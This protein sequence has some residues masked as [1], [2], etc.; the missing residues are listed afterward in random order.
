MT[1]GGEPAPS[2]SASG[3]IRVIIR[4]YEE[5]DR[6]LIRAICCD[7]ANRGEPLDPLLSDRELVA[8]LLTRYYT[9]DDPA[10]TWV[11][12]SGGRVIG[13]LTGCLDTRRYEQLMSQR[14]VPQ[15]VMEAIGRGAL[16]SSQAWRFIGAGLQTWVRGGFGPH[17]SLERFPAHLHVNVLRGFRGQ[18]VGRRLVDGFVLQAREAGVGGIH[19]RVRGDNPAACRFFEALGFQVLSRHPVVWPDGAGYLAYEAVL[20]GRPLS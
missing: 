5:L 18:D 19:A 9:D 17:A 2:S 11:A 16:A 7:T 8:D 20:Y 15:A 12:E 6:A 10:G 1:A 3:I 13:Y 4:R 14:V